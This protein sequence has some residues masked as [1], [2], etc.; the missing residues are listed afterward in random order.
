[1]NN[2]VK[3]G[4]ISRL[5]LLSDKQKQAVQI[6]LFAKKYINSLI[7][8]YG[9]DIMISDVLKKLSLK[10]VEKLYL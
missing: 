7:F 6:L 5:S 8:I 3:N 10:S 9:N 2:F 4:A 1:M